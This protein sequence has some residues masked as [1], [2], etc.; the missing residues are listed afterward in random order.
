MTS[1]TPGTRSPSAK[2]GRGWIPG[3]R[4]VVE[5][6]R[7]LADRLAGGQAVEVDR[8]AEQTS[9]CDSVQAMPVRDWDGTSYDR[10]SG[11]MQSM[12]LE[13]LSR[14]ELTGDETVIDA[15]C[16]SGRVTE[17]LLERLPRGA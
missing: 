12:G 1:R 9:V 17:A 11:V 6:P 15:G 14:L 4:L 10:I 5:E 13:V 8:G 3:A 16:G 7:G 2:L